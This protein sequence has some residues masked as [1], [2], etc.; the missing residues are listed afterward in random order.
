MTM[1]EAATPKPLNDSEA[2]K[3]QDEQIQSSPADALPD[4]VPPPLCRVL[5]IDAM[6]TLQGL[7]KSPGMTAI[8]HLKETFIKKVMNMS[9][10]YDEVRVLFDYY[11][12]DSLKSK[13]RASRATSV[14]ASEASYDV[15]DQMCIKTLSLK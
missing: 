6:A 7:K 2:S 11:R 10:R 12:E 4:I 13:T 14:A 1:I 15:H 3:D 5:I 9:R 8:R